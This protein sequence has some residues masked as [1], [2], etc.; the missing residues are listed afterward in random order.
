MQGFGFNK[1]KIVSAK[2]PR[3]GKDFEA[4]ER[5]HIPGKSMCRECTALVIKLNQLERQLL[6]EEFS[7]EKTDEELARQIN[8]ILIKEGPSGFPEVDEQLLNS[9]LERMLADEKRRKRLLK[10][11]RKLQKR[12]R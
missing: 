8:D 9:L 2:C 1:I 12:K 6:S 4:S 11:I 3:C 10:E 5:S 7:I